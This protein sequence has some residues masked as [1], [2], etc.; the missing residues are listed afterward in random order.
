MI[1]KRKIK[2]YTD[3]MLYLG[4]KKPIS[5]PLEYRFLWS[6][7][8]EEVPP[9]FAGWKRVCAVKFLFSVFL[10]SIFYGALIAILPVKIVDY[11]GVYALLLFGACMLGFLQSIRY[12]QEAE[13]LELP[14]W[15]DYLSERK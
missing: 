9:L 15:H 13:I 5:A 1:F 10:I 3:E 14:D 2:H 6:L 8:I 4:I 11:L 12:K 7:G